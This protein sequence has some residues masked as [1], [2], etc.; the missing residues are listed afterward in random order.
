MY[1]VYD[2]LRFQSSARPDAPFLILREC[3][4]TFGDIR[5]HVEALREDLESAGIVRGDRVVVSCSAADDYVST[6]L[7]VWSL[8]A[9]VAPVEPSLPEQSRRTLLEVSQANWLVSAENGD[10]LSVERLE[11]SNANSWPTGIREPAQLLFTS[12]SSGVPKAVILGHEAI[13]AA[14]IECADSLAL[15][16]NDIQMTTVPFW[17][18]YGQNRGLN[19]TLFAGASIAPVFD[20]DLSLRIAELKRI[21]PTVLLSMASF[22]GF[23]AYYRRPLG[24]HLRV[25]VAGAAPLP[26]SVQTKFEE[27]YGIPLMTTYG[28][29]EFLLISCQRLADDRSRGGVGYPCRGV[30]IRIIDENGEEV[31]PGESGQILVRGCHAMEGYLG[32][33]DKK[34]SLDGWLDTE[35]IGTLDQ[36]GLRV[37]GRASAF[38]KRSGYKVYPIEIQNVVS[39]HPDVVDVAVAKFTGSLGDEDLA[40]EVV[41][42]DGSEVDIADL[43]DYCRAHLPDYKIPAK[44]RLV[45]DI[46][47]LPSGKPDLVTIGKRATPDR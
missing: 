39:K 24:N 6:V 44:C 22:Y 31:K 14:A 20:D 37:L 42:R 15:S 28:L 33:P 46:P 9:V 26:T 34:V 47:R 27:L 17:H 12:G 45:E 38:I 18:A 40:V 4:K 10:Q 43:L 2:L 8:R 32:T 23:L 3:I 11:C 7:A 35:D 25:A 19:A 41:L 13:M 16:P 5:V 30:E 29:T 1:T 36:T 21:Q